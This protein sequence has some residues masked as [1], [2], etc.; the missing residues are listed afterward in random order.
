V[1]AVTGAKIDALR[2]DRDPGALITVSKLRHGP[3]SDEYAPLSDDASGPQ[4]L[5]RRSAALASIAV[6]AASAL[7]IPEM[8]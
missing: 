4:T 7:P 2:A 8:C 1:A 6:L 5:L 3:A